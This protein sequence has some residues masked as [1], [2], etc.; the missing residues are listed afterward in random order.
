MVLNQPSTIEW[1]SGWAIRATDGG[2]SQYD[3]VILR[4]EE[5]E[6]D[7]QRP[8]AGP[9]VCVRV[10]ASLA[11]KINISIDRWLHLHESEYMNW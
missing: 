5:R 8:S 2:G 1:V 4:K 6:T 10:S 7:V 3:V 9:V 11:K